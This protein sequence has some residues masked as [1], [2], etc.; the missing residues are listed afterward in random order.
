MRLADFQPSQETRN[1]RCRGGFCLQRTGENRRGCR[2]PPLD[3]AY[4]SGLTHMH[5][6]KQTYVLSINVDSCLSRKEI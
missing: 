3:S 6:L 1:P 4:V 2:I 5:I